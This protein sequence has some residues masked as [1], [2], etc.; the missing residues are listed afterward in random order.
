MVRLNQHWCNEKSP[1]SSGE[2][3]DRYGDIDKAPDFRIF[4]SATD[5][6]VECKK[7]RK[8]RDYIPSSPA[9]QRFSATLHATLVEA[10]IEDD[11]SLIWPRRAVAQSGKTR[12]LAGR[13]S[14]AKFRSANP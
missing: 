10:E 9:I 4:A 11:F 12:S 5:L 13:R 1:D 6:G 7:P 2:S 14:L 8:G 3:V